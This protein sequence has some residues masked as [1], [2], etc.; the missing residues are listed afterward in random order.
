MRTFI[1][2]VKG[3]IPGELVS[4]N[5]YVKVLIVPEGG[6]VYGGVMGKSAYREHIGPNPYS[7]TN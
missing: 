1:I 4:N 3:V 2:P 5:K 6:E 7:L